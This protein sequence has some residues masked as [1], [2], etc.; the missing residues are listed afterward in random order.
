MDFFVVPTVRFHP[1]YVWLAI[2]HGR[3]R[4]LHPQVSGTK[5]FAACRGT[6]GRV[7]GMS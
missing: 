5:S 6:E 1:L 7:C 3:K 4:I 2:D